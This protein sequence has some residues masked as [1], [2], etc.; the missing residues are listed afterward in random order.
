MRALLPALVLAAAG[1]AGDGPETRLRA[2]I[3]AMERAAE[4][5]APGEFVGHLSRDFSGEGALDREGMRR[6]LAARMLVSERIEV[7][8]GPLDVRLH[9][10]GRATVQVDA[11][12]IGGRWLPER[13][14]RFTVTSGWRLEGDEWRCYAASWSLAPASP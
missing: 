14:E 11:L 5:R 13:G 12:V 6:L 7:V 4:A 10:G 2:T 3:A 9:A 8:L 1:C